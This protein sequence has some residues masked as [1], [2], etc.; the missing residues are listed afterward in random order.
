MGGLGDSTGSVDEKPSW[1]STADSGD[2]CDDDSDSSYTTETSERFHVDF[3]V[4]TQRGS[5]TFDDMSTLGYSLL[6]DEQS[7]STGCSTASG[8]NTSTTGPLQR[9]T[10]KQT[11]II[12][13]SRHSFVRRCSTSSMRSNPSPPS[14]DPISEEE[15]E[16]EEDEHEAYLRAKMTSL[17]TR[18]Q[19]SAKT[20]DLSAAP[21]TSQDEE[22]IKA[23]AAKRY[24]LASMRRSRQ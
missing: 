3:L 14:L 2:D 17:W 1:L 21:C 9:S 10:N 22:L 6:S 24:S 7:V 18:I 19:E 13:T 23:Y 5:S 16:E 15:E 20:E 4:L 11:P 12:G 8:E